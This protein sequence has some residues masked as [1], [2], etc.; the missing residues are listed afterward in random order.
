MNTILFDLDGTL[1]PMD[2][3]AFVE[4]YFKGL[5]MKASELGVSSDT[6]LQGVWAGTKAMLVNDG[7]ASNEQVFW[8]TFASLLGESVRE[9]E[10][11]FAHFYQNEFHQTKKV[12]QPRAEVA[13]LVR[14]LKEK[15][16]QLILA[17]NP[18]FPRVATQAR[19]GWAGLASED[20]M[21][22]TTYEN[23]S[24]AKPNLAYYEEILHQNGLSAKQCMMIGNDVLEDMVAGELGMK[25]YLVTD[26][27]IEADGVDH[28]LYHQGTFADLLAF[29]DSLPTLSLCM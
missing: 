7:K 26:C 16:Y 3:N 6:L 17:T 27:M 28:S 4:S 12:T 13:T 29:A 5:S 10:P 8:D 19:L 23:S 22:I 2:Q 18:L 21:W 9:S 20:F 25:T 11:V 15:G 1:L 24:F 14:M